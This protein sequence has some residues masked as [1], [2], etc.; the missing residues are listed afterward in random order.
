MS[1]SNPVDDLIIYN[2]EQRFYAN[3]K[4]N[5]ESAIQQMKDNT[6]LQEDIVIMCEHKIISLETPQE[7]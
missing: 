5:A 1:E 2:D 7:E 4:E 6:K 3:V